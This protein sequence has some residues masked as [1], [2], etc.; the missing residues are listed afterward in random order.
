LARSGERTWLLQPRSA[1]AGTPAAK[2][3]A[4]ITPAQRRATVWLNKRQ[5]WWRVELGPA[6]DAVFTYMNDGG[7]RLA[8]AGPGVFCTNTLHRVVFDQGV[9]DDRKIAAALSLISSF[10]QLAAEQIGRVYGGGVLKFE[11]CDARRIPILFAT[12]GATTA[13]LLKVDAALRAGEDDLARDLADEA[14]LRPLLGSTWKSATTQMQEDLRRARD[15][16]HNG[17]ATP[18]LR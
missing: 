4:E 2:R 9:G 11:L 14:L 16:R 15:A 18:R 13:V 6:C 17:R 12:P 3:L 1:E 10:G 8:L 7:P 5:P